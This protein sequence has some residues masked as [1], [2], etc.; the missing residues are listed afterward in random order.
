VSQLG[1]QLRLEIAIEERF[2]SKIFG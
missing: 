2:N 1:L